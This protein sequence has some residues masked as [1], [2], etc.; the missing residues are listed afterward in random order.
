MF[1]K[2]TWPVDE[3]DSSQELRQGLDYDILALD[4]QDVSRAEEKETKKIKVQHYQSVLA[5][6]QNVLSTS[7]RGQSDQHERLCR[8]YQGQSKTASQYLTKAL[9][10]LSTSKGH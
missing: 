5:G 6:L 2:Q 1:R 4:L 3:G 8:N 7:Q 10:R 9:T